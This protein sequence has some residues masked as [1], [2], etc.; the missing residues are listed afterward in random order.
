MLKIT[1]S[2]SFA[3]TEVMS[4]NQKSTML[5]FCVVGV[6][7]DDFFSLAIKEVLKKKK[8]NRRPFLYALLDICCCLICASHY[9]SSAEQLLQMPSSS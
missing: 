8:K 4:I 1:V 3:G 9:Y 2:H 5:Q 7:I 6:D